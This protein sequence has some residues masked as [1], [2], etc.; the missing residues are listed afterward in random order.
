MKRIGLIGCLFF[1]VATGMHAQQLPAATTMQN[2]PIDKLLKLYPNPAV[3][4]ITFEFKTAFKRGLTLQVY[5][6]I[7]GKKMIDTRLT[8]EKMT[9]PL[10]EFTRGI[11]VYHL[12]ESTGKIIESGK[13]QV[14]K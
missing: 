2:E 10:T 1:A 14:T 3:S 12:V 11:Y 7:L 9:L 4:Y 5:N 6:G 8:V 13:F